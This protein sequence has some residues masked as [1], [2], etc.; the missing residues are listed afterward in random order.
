MSAADVDIEQ[1]V[2][3]VLRQLDGSSNPARPKVID[4]LASA[5]SELYLGEPVITLSHFKGQLDGIKNVSVRPT[6]VVTPAVRDLLKQRGIQLTRTKEAAKQTAGAV[7][8]GSA[9][10][11]YDAAGLTRM[12]TQQ[13]IGT[14]RL[15]QCGLVAVVDELVDAVARGGKIG[16][17]LTRQTAAALCLANRT[18]GVQAVLATSVEAIRTARTT[19]AANLLVLDPKGKAAHE[20]AGMIRTCATL[21]PHWADGLRPRLS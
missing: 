16:V 2:R 4:T 1:I 21:A 19:L 10:T 9:E 15:A 8:I 17:L 20:L 11:N 5:A 12:L 6:A 14:E 13:G 7:V 3:Q 18:R